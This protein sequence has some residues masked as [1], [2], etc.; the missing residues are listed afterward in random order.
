MF[1]NNPKLHLF[2]H[3][4]KTGGST[5]KRNIEANYVLGETYFHFAINGFKEMSKIGKLPFDALAKIKDVNSQDIVLFGHKVSE[6]F[7]KNRLH[8]QIE[9]TTILRH[10]FSRNVSQF[11]MRQ[12]ASKTNFSKTL[13]QHLNSSKDLTCKFMVARFPSFVSNP[14][15]SLFEQAKEVMSHFHNISVLEDAPDSIIETLKVYGVDYDKSLDSN[16]SSKK[17]TKKNVTLEDLSL[18]IYQILRQDLELYN[19]YKRNKKKQP[20]KDLPKK[21]HLPNY[22]LTYFLTKLH[23]KKEFVIPYYDSLSNPILKK[24]VKPQL[25]FDKLNLQVLLT[26]LINTEHESRLSEEEF[27]NFFDVFN[28]ILKRIEILPKISKPQESTYFGKILS[29]LKAQKCTK[30]SQLKSDIVEMLPDNNLESLLAKANY[31][32]SINEYQKALE[33]LFTVIKIY[34]LNLTAFEEMYSLAHKLKDFRLLTNCKL[35][36]F[37]LGGSNPNNNVL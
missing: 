13:K 16:I 17:N 1:S 11:Y 18:N 31:Y 7:L 27:D 25:A 12:N 28:F 10:P 20:Q 32:N 14:F 35:K 30:V 21:I 26:T 9:L 2:A 33:Y 22:W 34:P 4:P 23:S 29:E 3:L 19:Y 6:A 37:E 36:I 15:D 24:L 8:N 5:I